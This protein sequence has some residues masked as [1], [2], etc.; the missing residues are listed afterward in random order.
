MPWWFILF[1]N[2]LIIPMSQERPPDQAE[3]VDQLSAFLDGELDP[4]ARRDVE[5]LLTTSEEARA[6]LKRLEQAWD[7]LDELP[8]SE[9][10]P[11]FTQ[12][13]VAMIALRA[14]EDTE[15]KQSSPAAKW[16]SSWLAITG[17]LLMAALAGFLVVRS[18]AP[19]GNEQ[20]LRD[21]A[22]LENLEAY[23]QAESVEFL[24]KL[25]ERGSHFGKE[26][27]HAVAATVVAESMVERR[28]RV[29]QM[30]PAEKEH[31]VH[32][33]QRFAQ[34]EPA[35]QD[36][37]R[38]LNAALESA[39]DAAELRQIMDRYH[40]WLAQLPAVQRAE[41]LALDDDKRIE[42]I[43]Q[44]QSEET[45][46]LA[47]KLSPH[48]AQVVARWLEKRA[49]DAMPLSDFERATLQ[50]LPEAERRRMLFGR[51]AQRMPNAEP[52]KWL[53]VGKEGD[54][55][56]L[57]EQLSPEAREQLMKATLPREKGL[58]FSEWTRQVVG[59]YLNRGEGNQAGAGGIISEERLREF[60]EKELTAEERGRLVQLPPEEMKAAVRRM[61]AFRQWQK[62]EGTPNQRNFRP[63]GDIPPGPMGGRPGGRPG[64]N[65]GAG[66][67]PG[68]TP[69][70]RPSAPSPDK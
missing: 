38:T 7:F 1:G 4:A 18:A 47:R 50:K 43:A 57:R 12:T 6:E 41:F 32:R 9:V 11:S 49:V 21:L 31:V 48:D 34:L 68:Q 23:R 70:R 67:N 19:D 61:Y 55:V 15:E 45:Q 27:D 66:Q 16:S 64:M 10:S 40:A 17:A 39:P 37:L 35:E 60:F 13:T 8:R 56:A 2:D 53:P 59:E 69:L 51:L 26:A 36:R 29:A 33:Q 20:L 5:E 52:G 44:I 14:S 24:K 25:K 58:L 62:R 63:G 3:L 54:F 42:R 65:P 22:I 28:G 46:R 30:T